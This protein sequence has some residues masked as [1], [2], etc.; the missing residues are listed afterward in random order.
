MTARRWIEAL[1]LVLAMSAGWAPALR[2]Q[3]PAAPAPASPSPP[4]AVAPAPPPPSPAPAPPTA[5]PA[6]P[7]SQ[8]SRPTLVPNPGDP[9]NADEVV[10][11]AK[12]AI[13]V[14]GSS[15]WDDGFKAIRA[16]FARAEG[17]L[18]RLGIAPAG[19]P[20]TVFVNTTDDRFQF[21]ALVPVAA[22]PDPVPTLPEGVKFGMTP[23]GKTY[24]FVHQGAYEE[25]ETTYDTITSYLEAKDIAA[26]D[27]FFE[28][29]VNDV[30][31]AKDPKLE[32]N[33]FVQPR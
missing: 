6:P 33:I 13:V 14:V 21:E 27:V 29:Y 11:V 8:T 26:K 10:L 17:E 3:A 32:V 20:I 22:A 2:A 16:A 24:R 28:E 9:V 25:I 1:V 18:A 30:T 7:S 4:G 31:D 12:P 19:R 23:S 15:G 5:A